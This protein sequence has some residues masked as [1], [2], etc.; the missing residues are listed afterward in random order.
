MDKGTQDHDHPRTRPTDTREATWTRL[1][2]MR[3]NARFMAAME[4]ALADESI[5]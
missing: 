1:E 2:L 4:R 5:A 3:M